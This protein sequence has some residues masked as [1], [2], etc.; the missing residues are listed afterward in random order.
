MPLFDYTDIA[1]VIVAV[2]RGGQRLGAA[3]ASAHK[4]KWTL[5]TGDSGHMEGADTR[6]ALRVRDGMP[7]IE[8]TGS[9]M[10]E[11]EEQLFQLNHSAMR[12]I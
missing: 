1:S 8:G 11:D 2:S 5:W 10:E 3:I 7:T 12:N 6:I 9:P 4:E